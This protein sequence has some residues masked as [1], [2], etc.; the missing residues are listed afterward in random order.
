MTTERITS[1]PTVTPDSVVSGC[2]HRCPFARGPMFAWYCG[3]MWD[4]TTGPKGGI[5]D[6]NVR[7]PEDFPSGK[8]SKSAPSDCPLRSGPV[9][10]YDV[11]LVNRDAPLE[12]ARKVADR[13]VMP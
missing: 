12:E 2:S 3:V 11:I 6:K 10:V 4:R 1:I 7:C 9:T 13:K 5:K 8:M